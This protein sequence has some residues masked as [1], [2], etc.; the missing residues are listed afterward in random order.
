MKIAKV[1]RIRSLQ[2]RKSSFLTGYAKL[3][4]SQSVSADLSLLAR[5]PLELMKHLESMAGMED[6]LGAQWSVMLAQFA[7]S[8]K[9]GTINQRN[10][11]NNRACASRARKLLIAMGESITAQADSRDVV[12]AIEAQVE[13]L[14]IRYGFSLLPDDLLQDIL[15]LATEKGDY[16]EG[17]Q[18]GRDFALEKPAMYRALTLAHACSR[19]RS[20][21]LTTPRIWSAISDQIKDTEMLKFWLTH[22]GDIPLDVGLNTYGFPHFGKSFEDGFKICL[23]SSLRWRSFTLGV[24]PRST[25]ALIDRISTATRW[26]V[27]RNNILAIDSMTSQLHLPLLRHLDIGL[28]FASLQDRSDPRS[29][30][31]IHWSM[32]SLTSVHFHNCT[33]MIFPNTITHFSLLYRH[34]GLGLRVDKPCLDLRELANFLLSCAHLESVDIQLTTS[35]ISTE[36]FLLP[37]VIPLVRRAHLTVCACSPDDMLDFS[38]AFQFCDATHLQLG[39][40]CPKYDLEDIS[41]PDYEPFV[42]AVLKLHSQLKSLELSLGYIRIGTP[43]IIPPIAYLRNLEELTLECTHWDVWERSKFPYG[44]YIPA[45]VSLEVKL[46]HIGQWNVATKWVERLMIRLKKQGDL[47]RFALLTV[48]TTTGKPEPEGLLGKGIYKHLDAERIR[49]V[50]RSEESKYPHTF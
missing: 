8:I 45:L 20:I 38:H 37:A 47:G 25:Q 29:H 16:G 28:P 1:F 11:A 17:F 23:T 6:G 3:D 42:S 44:S 35:T 36:S 21:V 40:E 10:C 13:A 15:L 22:S 31:Y 50:R 12:R 43:F 41:K 32:P 48:S 49:F 33:P 46:S 2:G 26:D 18:P 34:P 14:G 19:F 39:I 24:I 4:D 5:D 7:L 30:S 9:P 27:V